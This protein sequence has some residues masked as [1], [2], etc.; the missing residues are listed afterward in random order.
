MMNKVKEG[1]IRPVTGLLLLT[2]VVVL[3][4]WIADIY[5]WQVMDTVSGEWVRVQ[6]LLCAEGIRWWLR[7]TVDNF[8]RYA[9]PDA[10]IVLSLG[11]G[12]A[13]HALS[14]YKPRSHK[15][16]RAL[17]GASLVLALY[18]L[19]ILCA[20]FSSWGILRGA[21]GGLL[22]SP[23]MEGLPFLL[24]VGFG[25]TGFVYGVVSGRYRREQDVMAGLLYLM[26]YVGI[27]FVWTFFAS[28]LLACLDYTRLDQYVW[29][30]FR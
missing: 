12:L 27:Y 19:L 3:V 16:R 23:F 30:L 24:S 2:G 1:W 5:G 21:N 7:S 14:G 20:T 18:S 10:V 6:S 25:L 17:T 9:I 15:S 29:L 26:P 4:S 11:V 8:S 13:L 28:Q 22:R